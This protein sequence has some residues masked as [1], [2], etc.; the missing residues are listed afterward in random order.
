LNF[1]SHDVLRTN[2]RVDREKATS[3]SQPV[4]HPLIARGRVFDSSV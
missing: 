2:R 1:S 4:A 3:A